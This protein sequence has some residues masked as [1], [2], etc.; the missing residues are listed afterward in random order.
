M[1][2]T[3]RVIVFD[4]LNSD[5]IVVK[6]LTRVSVIKGPQMT[7]GQSYW[8]ILTLGQTAWLATCLYCVKKTMVNMIQKC[9]EGDLFSLLVLSLIPEDIKF[10]KN[11]LE[12][13]KGLLKD[14]SKP[15][16]ELSQ[17]KLAIK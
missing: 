16:R 7:W 11:N 2:P 4:L 12:I 9:Q 17:Q 15:D 14:F 13:A 3:S 5:H 1:G 10:T 6:Q 8:G